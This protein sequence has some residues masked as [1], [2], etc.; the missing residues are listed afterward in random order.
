LV[1]FSGGCHIYAGFDR[2][3]GKTLRQSG[4]DP[5]NLSMAVASLISFTF[6][7]AGDNYQAVKASLRMC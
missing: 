6:I 7:V 3:V 5:V 1:L 2:L 4:G